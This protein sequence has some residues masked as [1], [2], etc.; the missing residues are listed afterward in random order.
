[1]ECSTKQLALKLT[2][3]FGAKKYVRLFRSCY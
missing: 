2:D 1:M 3:T